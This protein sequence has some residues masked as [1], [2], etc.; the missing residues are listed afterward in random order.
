MGSCFISDCTEDGER[1][2][3]DLRVSIRTAE[4]LGRGSLSIQL[5]TEDEE[6]SHDVSEGNGGHGSSWDLVTEVDRVNIVRG[7]A[8]VVRVR[9]AWVN[10][11]LSTDQCLHGEGR[12]RQAANPQLLAVAEILFLD[13]R[14]PRGGSA[15]TASNPLKKE[16]ALR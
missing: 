5:Q 4:E 10:G 12:F 8:A 2:A 13:P 6:R 16:N 15:A 1:I 3:E 11:R 9:C 7:H 14:P